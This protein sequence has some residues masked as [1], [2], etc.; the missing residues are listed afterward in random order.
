MCSIMLDSRRMLAS[1]PPWVMSRSLR[2]TEI[3]SRN[4]DVMLV[5]NSHF[6]LHGKLQYTT[7]DTLKTHLNRGSY[8][9]G[10]GSNG[11]LGG[12]DMTGKSTVRFF[13]PAKAPISLCVVSDM[14]ATSSK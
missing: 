6:V 7:R 9:R 14:P 3:R 12:V 2:S 11:I 1:A 13:R 10:P 5:N 4:Q 8:A